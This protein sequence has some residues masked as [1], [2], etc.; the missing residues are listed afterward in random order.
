MFLSF[1]CFSSFWKDGPIDP[2][3]MKTQKHRR[4]PW[5]RHIQHTSNT[6]TQIIA[7][8][9][10]FSV[11]QWFLK[12]GSMDPETIETQETQEIPEEKTLI[13]HIQYRNTNSRLCFCL[14]CVPMVSGRM[15][16]WIHKA[17]KRKETQEI[18]EKRRLFLTSKTK[19]QIISCV[20]VFSVFRWCLG[21]WPHGSRK[22]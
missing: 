4:F 6:E 22:H 10:V 19:T 14:F 2:E 7:C 12:D 9:S 13:S 16:P 21:G 20:S 1:L 8:V 18:P 17:L 11:F 15:A 3:S 5:K